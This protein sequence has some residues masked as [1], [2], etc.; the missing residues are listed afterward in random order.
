MAVNMNNS[1]SDFQAWN[2]QAPHITAIDAR[3]RL[4]WSVIPIAANKKPAVKWKEYQDKRPDKETLQYWQ[5]QFSPSAWVLITGRLSGRIVLEFDGEEGKETL[6]KL[7]LEP[8]MRSGS[9][10]F[11]VHFKHP[12]WR[13]K[14]LNHIS[15][16]ELGQRWPGMDIRGDGGYAAFCGRNT[17]G[18][19]I[20]LRDPEPYDLEILPDNLREFLG[21]LHAPEPPA[22][23]PITAAASAS[24]KQPGTNRVGKSLANV[25][26]D[27]YVDLAHSSRHRDDSCF[28]MACQL[29]DNDFSKS[30]AKSI[31]RTFAGR[32]PTTN[33]KGQYEPFTE[34]E[35]ELKVDSA[36]GE[37]NLARKPWEPHRT[38][39]NDQAS[40]SGNNGNGRSNNNHKSNGDGDKPEPDVKFILDCLFQNEY[41]DAKLFTHLFKGE[42]LY[43]ATAQEWYL[44]NKHSWQIDELGRVKHY[45]SG[46]LASVY[47]KAC[48]DLNLQVRGLEPAEDDETKKKIA[49]LKEQIKQLTARA[50]ALRSRSRNANVLTFVAAFEGMA[51]VAE[52][53]DKDPWLIATPN[54][55]LHLQRENFGLKPGNPTDYIRS[56]IPTEWK[57]L[58]PSLKFVTFLR[59]LFEMRKEGDHFVKRTEQ[60]IDEIVSFLQRLFGYGITG[61]VFEHIFAV[62]WGE[63][64]RNGKD[65]LIQ[66]ISYVLGCLAGAIPKD[67]FLDFGKHQA[68]GAPSPHLM[69]LKAKRIAWANEP[70]KGAKFT[71]D[72]IKDVTGGGDIKARNP[73]DKRYTTIKPTH[74]LFLLTNHKPH[75]DANDSAFWS[76]LR[77]IT[78]DMRF[79]DQPMAENERPKNNHL[80]SE[81]EQEASGILAWLVQGCLDWQEHGLATPEVILQ[82]G[83]Q[84]REEEDTLAQFIQECCIVHPDANV[85]ASRLYEAYTTWCKSQPGVFNAFSNPTF[86]LQMKKKNFE[87]KKEPLGNFYY[88]LG[89]PDA[90]PDPKRY[91][92]L[93]ME[94]E[95]GVHSTEKPCTPASQATSDSTNQEDSAGCAYFSQKVSK[96]GVYP[97]LKEVPFRKSMH[98]LHT[99][100][101]I[102]TINQPVEPCEDTVHS[103][104]NPAQ[105]DP[106]TKLNSACHM[107]PDRPAVDKQKRCEECHLEFLASLEEPEDAAPLPERNPFYV[108]LDS[109]G[110][111]EE[112]YL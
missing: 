2:E 99:D 17:K 80:W 21:L 15:C 44:W 72:Q 3:T 96:P 13:V 20:W 88:G 104:N 71:L 74:L 26:L 106:S 82:A 63:D 8:H 66:A 28:A 56:V 10:G 43:D 87:K 81:L 55:V 4:G 45:V 57:S 16:Q 68:G 36:Y 42:V 93:S 69:D 25:I 27:K 107:H 9:G 112:G 62:L 64:G 110:N 67:V 101:N 47:L 35:A 18:P 73:F 79:V 30:E 75:A 89:L 41:G 86:G 19:Y 52:Q 108:E 6:E 65:T 48:A 60:E 22:P 24:R 61:F 102:H 103:L 54:G 53:W 78:F 59:S 91:K 33:S 98:T 83:N 51:I 109:N 85:K 5:H 100:K 11:H 40:Y 50:I 29:R 84:Y 7:G 31:A 1:A 76:R 58:K 12:G 90:P 38:T 34:T 23:I 105:C 46:H 95:D 49:Y 111:Y 37:G 92:Q 94:N 32:V 14:T 77:L 97:P 70:A 39:T